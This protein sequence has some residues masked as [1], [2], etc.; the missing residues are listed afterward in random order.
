M[1][2]LCSYISLRVVLVQTALCYS[3]TNRAVLLSLK[4]EIVL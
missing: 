1:D 3:S 4:I 2:H